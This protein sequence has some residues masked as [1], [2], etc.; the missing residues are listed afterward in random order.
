M[1]G[2]LGCI[3]HPAAPGS[4]PVVELDLIRRSVSSKEPHGAHMIDLIRALLNGPVENAIGLSETMQQETE[5]RET[6]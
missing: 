2:L 5:P 1:V 6:E 4:K 3:F